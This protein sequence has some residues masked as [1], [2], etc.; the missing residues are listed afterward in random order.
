M[1][2]ALAEAIIA[3]QLCNN[4]FKDFHIPASNAIDFDGL[5]R[6]LLRLDEKHPRKASIVR[7]QIAMALDD[8]QDNEASIGR[9]TEGVCRLLGPCM[10]DG[11]VQE[12]FS[13]DLTAFFRD[14]MGL[15]KRVQRASEHVIATASVMFDQWDASLDAREQYDRVVVEDRYK[16]HEAGLG[17]ATPI[18]ILFPQ[19]WIG[20][21]DLFHGFALFP[22]QTAVIAANIENKNKNSSGGSSNRR[23]QS[24]NGARHGP[25]QSPLGSLASNT[26]RHRA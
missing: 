7:C 23:R 8:H 16:A 1:R 24:V 12:Q 2:S 6:I 9:A 22:S 20:K 25:E 14:A 5:A 17:S 4:I 19:I 21:R 15:W 26:S 3:S 18:A 10:P 11:A 13:K